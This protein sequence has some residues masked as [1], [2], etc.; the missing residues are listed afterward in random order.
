[1][2]VI[3]DKLSELRY[4]KRKNLEEESRVVG[5]YIRDIIHSYGIDCNFYKLKS[6]YSK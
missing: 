1:M 6:N 4:L 2:S 5:N 3:Q